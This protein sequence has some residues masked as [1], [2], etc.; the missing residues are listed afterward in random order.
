MKRLAIF[1]LLGL[2]PVLASAQDQAQTD[3]T[4]VMISLVPQYAFQSGFRFDVDLPLRD[5]H[6]IQL[7]PV[8]Y[9]GNNVEMSVN[10][11]DKLGG[12]GLH[13]YHRFYPEPSFTHRRP[14]LAWGPV[15][16]HFSLDYSL[17]NGNA[18]T[19]KHSNINRLGADLTVGLV[20]EGGTFFFDVFAGSGIR[21][22]FLSG[23]KD[24]TFNDMILDYGYSGVTLVAGIR[25]GVNI[26]KK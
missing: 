9:A 22:A 13:A 8:F 1:I 23:D 5:H 11:A 2:M 25:I 3:R 26:R 20:L 17:Y 16:Q 6:W 19:R 10:S 18:R 12:V 24:V 4:V 21:Q 14:Y 15:V 7:A